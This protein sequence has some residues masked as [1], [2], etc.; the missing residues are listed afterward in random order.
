MYAIIDVKIWEGREIH[1]V[2]NLLEFELMY[3]T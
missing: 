1:D 3:K 2:I